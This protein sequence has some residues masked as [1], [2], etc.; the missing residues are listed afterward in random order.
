MLQGCQLP[1]PGGPGVWEAWHRGGVYVQL[2]LSD[3]RAWETELVGGREPW[4]PF[5]RCPR[6]R[7]GP[8]T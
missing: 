6:S 8:L 3:D 5:I 7:L 1:Q 2:G 4:G